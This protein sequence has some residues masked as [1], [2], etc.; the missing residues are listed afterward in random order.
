VVLL[1]CGVIL[2]WRL[3]GF[4]NSPEALRPR[5]S[6]AYEAVAQMKAR[7]QR[8]EDPLWL[9]LTAANETDMEQRLARA[10]TALARAQEERRIVSFSLPDALWPQPAHQQANRAAA[11]ELARR[12]EEFRGALAA[13]GFTGDS[14]ALAKHVLRTWEAANGAGIFWPTNASST[15]L[16]DKFITRR[17]GEFLALALVQPATNRPSDELRAGLLSLADE[18]APD[19]MYLS[20]WSILGPAVF[21]RV[22]AD[23]WKVLAPMALLVVVSLW[24]AFR[25]VREVGLS[26][27]ALAVSGAGLWACMGLAGWSWNLMNLMGLPLLLGMG[28]DFAI[29]VQMALRRHDGDLALVRGGI[30]R[31]LLLAG[32]TTVAGFGSLALSSNAG[33]ASL[34][35]VCGTGIL[36]AMLVSVYLLPLWWRAS[37]RR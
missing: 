11:G 12:A 17:P 29:H 15:W 4:D 35:K 5:H 37:M 3:P 9:L 1:C 24:L 26:L 32:S 6:P 31:A 14:F 10:R 33:L 25:S 13:G 27:A 21:A 7:L 20:G 22:R 23:F 34:G 2:W 28:V 16:L 36:C 30:G 19:G 18:L 8:P